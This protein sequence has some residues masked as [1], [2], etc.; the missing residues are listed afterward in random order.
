MRGWPS[1][2]ELREVGGGGEGG[3]SKCFAKEAAIW[4]DESVAVSVSGHHP[5]VGK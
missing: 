4:K 1:R 5:A 2:R 3:S